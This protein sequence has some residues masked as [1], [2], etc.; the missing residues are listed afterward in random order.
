MTRPARRIK[1][2][3]SDIWIRGPMR[4][5]TS[6]TLASLAAPPSSAVD[7][8][9][10]DAHGG[11]VAGA[12]NLW[13]S[14]NALGTGPFTLQGYDGVGGGGYTL[15]PVHHYW[16]TAAA[17]GEPWNV[18][19]QPANTSIQI[20]FQDAIDV[21]ASDLE[22]GTYASAAFAYVGLSTVTALERRIFSVRDAA[23]ARATVGA[24]TE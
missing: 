5:H 6:L 18:M 7:P 13:M 11:V 23:A 21:T 3:K 22:N 19:I 24:D 4:S 14:T 8:A 15:S 20:I 10:I 1:P 17:M 2:T 12:V 9:V 16:A